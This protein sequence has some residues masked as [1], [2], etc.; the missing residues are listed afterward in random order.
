MRSAFLLDYTLTGMSVIEPETDARELK[1]NSS[2]Q[3]T[4]KDGEEVLLADDADKE[5]KQVPKEAKLK[6]VMKK[7]KSDKHKE[8]TPK[9]VKGVA[10]TSIAATS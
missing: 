9:R 8:K 2:F 1:E 10:Y 4:V 7:R 6:T 5:Q 3:S